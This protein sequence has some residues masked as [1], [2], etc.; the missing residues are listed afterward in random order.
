MKLTILRRWAFSSIPDSTKV[1]HRFPDVTDSLILVECLPGTVLGA[2]ETVGNG[3]K[4]LPS[5][6]FH[7]SRAEK[8]RQR[9]LE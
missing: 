5:K 1:W 9:T 2:G 7:L 4:P 3:N 8:I 6:N